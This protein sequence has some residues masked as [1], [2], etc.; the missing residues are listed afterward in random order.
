MAIYFIQQLIIQSKTQ[1]N[2]HTQVISKKRIF[3]KYC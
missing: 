2:I 1:K 3:P